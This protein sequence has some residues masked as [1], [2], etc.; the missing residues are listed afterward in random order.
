MTTEESEQLR[1]TSPGC[2]SDE[3]RAPIEDLSVTKQKALILCLEGDGTLHK[4]SGAWTPHW[5]PHEAR[6][7]GVTVADLAR[8]SLLTIVVREKRA[9]ACLTSRGAWFAQTAARVH[10]CV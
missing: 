4:R 5:E 7:S 2:V 10:R 9:S 8:D 6:V 1:S 3:R